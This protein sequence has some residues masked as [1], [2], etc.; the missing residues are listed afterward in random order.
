M[1]QD[2][3]IS[4]VQ[5]AT[6]LRATNSHAPQGA[7]L[8]VWDA[9]TKTGLSVSQNGT[10]KPPKPISN[11]ENLSLILEHDP[12]YQSLSYCVHSDKML[13]NDEMIEDHT[14]EEVALD[15]EV[16]YRY[17]TADVKLR[18]GIQR[19]ARKRPQDPLRDWLM[20]LEWDGIPRLT[21]LF[22]DYFRAG[23]AGFDGLLQE[24][25]LRW[26]ISCVARALTPGCKMD[27]CLVL[28]GFKGIFKST[29]LRTLCG[30]QWFSDSDLSIDHKDG[31]ELIHQSGVWI[32]ELS[33][34]HSLHGK[35]ADNA[36]QFLAS[37]VDRYRPSY[38]KMP[39]ERPRRVVF[40]ASS[41][42]W[43]FLSDGPERRFWPIVCGS[44]GQRIDI[45]AIT[46]DRTQLWAEAVAMFQGGHRWWLEGDHITELEQYQEVFLIDDPWAAGVAE[47]LARSMGEGTTRDIMDH[48][49]LPASQQHT[50]NS[51]RLAKILRDMNYHQTKSGGKR[52]WKQRNRA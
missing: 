23:S 33:E 19:A 38:G 32:W 21:K 46:R 10:I 35:S 27:T 51:R 42:E 9:L 50:G 17:T 40:T 41:N 2:K 25:G 49:Q 1:D 28:V 29:A 20:S 7:D 31:K 12:D 44:D 3:I 30:A 4:I 5:Q 39:V 52:L 36:K 8:D 34:M 26:P 45:E 48:L 37:Q 6:G 47:Y 18:S 14:L 43:Q 15:L 13:L 24:L 22:T 11:R 16:R